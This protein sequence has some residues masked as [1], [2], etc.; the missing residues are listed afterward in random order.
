VRKK[1][2]VN[3]EVNPCSGWYAAGGVGADLVETALTG[4][5][6]AELFAAW[7]STKYGQYVYQLVG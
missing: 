7:R 1:L 5:V 2:D 6:A 3:G 4:A